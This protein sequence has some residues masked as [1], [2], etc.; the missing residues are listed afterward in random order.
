MDEADP[1]E[2]DRLRQEA[3][4]AQP[5]SMQQVSD[6]E[7]SEASEDEGAGQ[8]AAVRWQLLL[9]LRLH[10]MMLLCK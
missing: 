3:V 9:L 8:E 1:A 4:D 10:M 6:D 2:V 5:D 7:D